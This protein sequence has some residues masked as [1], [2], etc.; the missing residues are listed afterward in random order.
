VDSGCDL[1]VCDGRILVLASRTRDQMCMHGPGYDPGILYVAPVFSRDG[2]SP[3]HPGLYIAGGPTVALGE[4]HDRILVA[5]W[6]DEMFVVDKCRVPRFRAVADKSE[7]E[8]LTGADME[9][10]PAPAEGERGSA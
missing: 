3:C 1:R 10:E 7:F 9:P 5:C 6:L 8:R 4:G 2:S